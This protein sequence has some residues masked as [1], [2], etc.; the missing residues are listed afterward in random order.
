MITIC[1]SDGIRFQVEKEIVEGNYKERT[2]SMCY[3]SETLIYVIHDTYDEE[4]IQLSHVRGEG[5]KRILEYQTYLYE[6][7]DT[8]LE[9]YDSLFMK[10][11]ENDS[12]GYPRLA[13]LIRDAN[14][15]GNQ[16][17]FAIGAMLAA[18]IIKNA[19][20]K[21]IKELRRVLAVE[22]DFT[23]EEEAHLQLTF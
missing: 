6:H 23:P 4:E 13:E 12:L 11:F 1:C 17:L 18:T 20:K 5:M 2:D 21:G 9:L 14:Y 8:P 16:H 7:P 22:N 15:L 3:G 10:E 19:V